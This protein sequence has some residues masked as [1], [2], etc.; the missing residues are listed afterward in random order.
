MTNKKLHRPLKTRLRRAGHIFV[1]T[2]LIVM[3]WVFYKVLRIQCII[4][5]TQ[6]RLTE[7]GEGEHEI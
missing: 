5:D 6:D 7:I 4:I 1:I 2:A 3:A